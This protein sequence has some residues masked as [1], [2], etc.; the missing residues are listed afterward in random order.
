[1]RFIWIALKVVLTIVLLAVAGVLVLM[2]T[3][4]PSDFT[5]IGVAAVFLFMA[6]L[7]WAKLTP[8]SRELGL[9]GVVLGFLFLFVAAQP[10]I[11]GQTYPRA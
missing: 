2:F 3:S 9:A 10:F 1:M 7:L 8:G 5:L 6:A 4:T 11:G